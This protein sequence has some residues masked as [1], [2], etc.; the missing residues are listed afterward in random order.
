MQL[1]PIYQKN[2]ARLVFLCKCFFDKNA[3]AALEY[4]ERLF[5]FTVFYYFALNF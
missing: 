5:I 4:R 3:P 2:W 1:L